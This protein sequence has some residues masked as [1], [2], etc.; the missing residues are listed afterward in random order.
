MKR[1]FQGKKLIIVSNESI[2]SSSSLFEAN[3]EPVTTVVEKL[4]KSGMT[5]DAEQL[6]KENNYSSEVVLSMVRGACL[7]RRAELAF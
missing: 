7:T 6:M 1:K 5:K 4:L 2:F 3:S